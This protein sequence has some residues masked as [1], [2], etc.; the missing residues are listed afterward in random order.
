MLDMIETQVRELS[1]ADISIEIDNEMEELG[2]T[3]TFS[4]GTDIRFLVAINVDQHLGYGDEALDQLL[5][6]IRHEVAHCEHILSIG[7]AILTAATQATIDNVE[8]CARFG[9]SPQPFE[10]HFQVALLYLSRGKDATHGPNW[11][12]FARKLGATPKA[13]AE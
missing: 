5:D 11:K 4:S 10:T 3:Y 1:T 6:T 7:E 12:K 13:K 8:M 2:A 9:I